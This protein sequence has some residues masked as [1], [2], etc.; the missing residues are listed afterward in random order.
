MSQR[1]NSMQAKREGARH[2]RRWLVAA[3]AASV[4]VVALWVVAK[5]G[6]PS[7]TRA[8]QV[9]YAP[10]TGPLTLPVS[11]SSAPAEVQAIYEFAARRPDV[12]H[13]L[14]CFCGCWRAGHKSNYDCFV[15]GIRDGGFVD[16][17]EMGFT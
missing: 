6:R 3:V 2:G 8:E 11:M 12:L 15:D 7:V 5:A 13:Y 16:I 4:I 9:S 17:D 1:N 10:V 14:P